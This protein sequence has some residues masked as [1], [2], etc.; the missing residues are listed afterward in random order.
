MATETSPRPRS[1][2]PSTIVPQKRALILDDEQHIPAVSSPLNPDA[3][4]SRSRK[5]PAREQRE[6]KESLKKREAKGVDTARSATPDT[7]TS[8]KKSKK[9]EKPPDVVRPLRYYTKPPNPSDFDPPRGPIFSPILEKANRDFNECFEQISNKKA[10]RYTNC[11]ADPSFPSSR[12]FRQTEASPFHPRF[13]F[14]EA[15]SHIL[16]DSTGRSITTEKG[17]RMARANVAAREGRWYYECKILSGVRP[18]SPSPSL[19]KSDTTGGGHVRLGWARREANLDTPLGFDAYSYGLRDVSGQ[20]VHMSRP[21]DFSPGNESFLEGDVIGLEITLPSLALHRKVVEGSYNKAV[22][23]SDDLDPHP[24]AEAPDIVRD[25]VPIRY[26]G[27]VYFEQFEYSSTKDLEELMNP[28]PS[29][30]TAATATTNAASTA[31][32]NPNHPSVGLRT[33]P[34]SSIKV[35]KNG[36]LLGAPFADLFAFLPPAS[37]PA[38]QQGARDGLD[39]GLLGYF[40]A[41]SVFRGGAVEVNFGPDFWCPPSDLAVPTSHNGGHHSAADDDDDDEPIMDDTNASAIALAP[42]YPTTRKQHTQGKNSRLRG[43][44]ERYVEQIAEDIV[45]DLV[46]EVDFWVLDAGEMA[47]VAGADEGAEAQ[48]GRGASTTAGM[49]TPVGIVEQAGMLGGGGGEIKEIVQ[50]EE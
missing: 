23:V 42:R 12:W 13:S 21:K 19:N 4:T 20:K 30:P 3:A 8:T 10:F 44:G 28:S 5:A 46:D 25:R 7:Q 1:A 50:E 15:S 41:I 18:P 47:D 9:I 17:F 35:Y 31:P 39:D 29:A 33:L 37:K 49:V 14:Q 26:K 38:A 11:I 16:F 43:M 34:F 48:K 32:P 24:A 36:K 6:K 27:I 40:P 45:Y 2:T 22:D